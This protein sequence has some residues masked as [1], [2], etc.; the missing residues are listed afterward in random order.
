MNKLLLTAIIIITGHVSTAQKIIYDFGS[1]SDVLDSVKVAMNFF[2]TEAKKSGYTSSNIYASIDNCDGN[3]NLAVTT[4]VKNDIGLK[5]LVKKTNR[6]IKL[7]KTELLPLIFYTDIL[8][9][10]IKGSR[11]DLPISGFYLRIIKSE[12]FTWRVESMRFNF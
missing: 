4:F 7:S 1:G 9:E 3:M 6:F 2:K 10:E 12:K 11:K 5:K 8:S